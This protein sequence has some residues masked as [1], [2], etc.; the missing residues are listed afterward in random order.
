MK[1]NKKFDKQFGIKTSKLQ[2]INCTNLFRYALDTKEL[3]L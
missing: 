3:T 1:Q 2:S